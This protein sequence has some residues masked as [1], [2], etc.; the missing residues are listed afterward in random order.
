MVLIT[1]ICTEILNTQEFFDKDNFF[2][3][4]EIYFFLFI[5]YY[6][7]NL[8]IYLIY[9]NLIGKNSCCKLK[10]FLGKNDSFSSIEIF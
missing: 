5:L 1:D 10:I 4:I 9:L 6:H 8:L 7:V 2:C 3:G